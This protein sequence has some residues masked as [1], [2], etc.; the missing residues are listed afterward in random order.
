MCNEARHQLDESAC[1]LSLEH[2]LCARSERQSVTSAS[3]AACATTW[4]QRYT[5]GNSQHR[6]LPLTLTPSRPD[7]AG[8]LLVAWGWFFIS[9]KQEP[10][11]EFKARN[12]SKSMKKGRAV[13]TERLGLSRAAATPQTAEPTDEARPEWDT[14][15]TAALPVSDSA[16]RRS[17]STDGVG[18]VRFCWSRHCAC[19]RLVIGRLVSNGSRLG[20]V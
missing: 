14:S 10:E 1:R 19:S 13:V 17:A 18:T 15:Y 7:S 8:L 6:V 5:T 11:P 4:A 9:T 20:W 3:C 16:L 2:L 12:L